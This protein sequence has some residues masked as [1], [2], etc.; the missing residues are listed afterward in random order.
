MKGF[1]IYKGVEGSIGNGNDLV[2]QVLIR[3]QL[4]AKEDINVIPVSVRVQQG[5]CSSICAMDSKFNHVGQ[6]FGPYMQSVS[7]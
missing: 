7:I 2:M 4:K 1:D 3:I 6:A 5:V